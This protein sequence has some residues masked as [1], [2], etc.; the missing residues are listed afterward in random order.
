MDTS[1]LTSIVPRIF[2]ARAYRFDPLTDLPLIAVLTS[3]ETPRGVFQCAN[4]CFGRVTG[5]NLRPLESQ[6]LLDDKAT[7]E[8]GGIEK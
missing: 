4:D 2:Q 6:Y 7:V 3:S 5:T 8:I 1:R